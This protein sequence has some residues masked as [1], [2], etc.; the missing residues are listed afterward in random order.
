MSDACLA[1][2]RGGLPRSYQVFMG[3]ILLT[4]SAF[5]G[6]ELAD[7]SVMSQV[8]MGFVVHSPCFSASGCCSS[9]RRRVGLCTS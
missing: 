6:L 3:R 5:H 7:F 2:G 8:G 4:F 9:E 1:M